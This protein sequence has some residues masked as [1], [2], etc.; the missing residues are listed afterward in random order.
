MKQFNKLMKPEIISRNGTSLISR[1]DFLKK[2][3]MLAGAFALGGCTKD[4]N[5]NNGNVMTI[6]RSGVGRAFFQMSGNG[7]TTIDWGDGTAVETQKLRTYDE[8]PMYEHTYSDATVRTI[9]ITGN[10]TWLNS[11]TKSILRVD[12]SKNKVLEKFDCRDTKITNLDVSKNTALT[13]LDCSDS[14]LTNLDVNKNTALTGLYCI[15]NRLTNL[16]VSKNVKLVQ[17]WCDNNQLT[18]LDVSKNVELWDIYC[19]GNQ[20]TSTELNALFGTLH[21]NTILDHRGVDRRGIYIRNNPGTA[22]CNQSIARDKGWV[23]NTTFQW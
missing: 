19:R 23:V 10:V 21:S 22:T 17:L 16:D 12:V 1:G 5:E 15:N 13:Y 2:A 4:D 9:K 6:T 14:Q 11:S 20:F 3:L 18:K 7:T 8:L